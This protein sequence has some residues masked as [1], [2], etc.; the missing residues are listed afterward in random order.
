MLVNHII[1]KGYD[2]SGGQFSKISGRMIEG[3]EWRKVTGLDFLG[4]IW[5]IQYSRKRAIFAGFRLIIHETGLP[6][7]TD[8][9]FLIALLRTI[10]PKKMSKFGCLGQE[11]MSL[12][13]P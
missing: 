7:K 10:I 13:Y 5:I 1:A 4:K 12:E 2:T 3:D 8:L 9:I 6:G 11:M